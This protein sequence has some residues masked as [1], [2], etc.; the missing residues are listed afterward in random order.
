MNWGRIYAS[1]M[2]EFH[3]TP[4]QIDEEMTLPLLKELDD[5]WAEYPPV[6]MLIPSYM[7]YKPK[8]KAKVKPGEVSGDLDGLLDLFGSS[9][10][11]A[12]KH[13]RAAGA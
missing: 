8:N 7:G 4:S 12:V 13:N 9:K 11:I 2:A 10:G 5:Y 3:Y 1:L 6:H